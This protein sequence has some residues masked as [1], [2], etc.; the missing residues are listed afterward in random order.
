MA[1]MEVVSIKTRDGR[2]GMHVMGAAVGP[3]V[4]FLMDGGGIRPGMIAMASRLAAYGY[5]VALP[6]LYYRSGSYAPAD[7]ARAL[8]PGPERDRLASYA[9]LLT[10][11]A[12]E[13]DL[14]AV[15]D[16]LEGAGATRVG[17]VGY[18]VGGRLALTAAAAFGARLAS[19]ASIHG[20]GYATDKLDSPHLRAAAMSAEIYLGVA[21]DDQWVPREE[22][23]RLRAALDA[24]GV[25][26]T[27]DVYEG[28]S[29]GFAVADL[30][31]CDP[32][33]AE[34]HWERVAT[35]FGRTL[36]A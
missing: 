5:R 30:P 8:V 10:S 25:R 15:L 14:G 22:T 6:D 19:V 16:W 27:L 11:E 21:G 28:V 36:Y 12:A 20:G 1:S 24:A 31:I 33:A 26:F 18:C 17:C 4:M 32:P 13:S 3:A 7:P 34:R 9:R 35:F 2:C 23:E 29:H